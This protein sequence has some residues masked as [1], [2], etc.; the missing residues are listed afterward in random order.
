MY[1]GT[2]D[3]NDIIT[4]IWIEVYD[5][6]SLRYLPHVVLVIILSF[7]TD[8]ESESSLWGP[9]GNA[10]GSSGGG[11]PSSGIVGRVEL[12]WYVAYLGLYGRSSWS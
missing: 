8:V 7:V 5:T 9:V 6:I 4:Q 10:T 12:P 11:G 2:I 1:F 3:L